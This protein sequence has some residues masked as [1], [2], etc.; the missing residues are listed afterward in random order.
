MTA[1]GFAD[2]H[3]RVRSRVSELAP[4]AEQLMKIFTVTGDPIADVPVLPG[5]A[6][7]ANDVVARLIRSPRH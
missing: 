2:L 3:K 4:V 7:D 1:T 5:T 6:Q